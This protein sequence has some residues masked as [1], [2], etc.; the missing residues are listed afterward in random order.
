MRTQTILTS[1]VAFVGTL[2]SSGHAAAGY[3]V[4]PNGTTVTGTPTFLVY[5]DDEERLPYV[6]VSTSPSV[7]AYGWFTTPG[8]SC[9][10]LD[11][12]PEPRK[13]SCQV[14]YVTFTPGRT[15]YWIFTYWKNDDCVSYS[16]GT[17]CYPQKHVS[18]PFSFTV[19]A[20]PPPPAPVQSPPP[21]LPTPAPRPSGSGATVH[22]APKL[23]SLAAWSGE[24]SIKHTRLTSLVYSLMKGFGR[25]R[26]LAVACW[27]PDDWLSVLDAEGETA[28]QHGSVLRGFWKP[29][30]PRWLHLSPAVCDDLQALLDT[31]Q[32][33]G[34]RASAVSTLVHE[35]LHAHGIR[36]E[37][38]TNC[39]A[40]QL[41]P[42]LGDAL[43]MPRA[44][45]VRLGTLAVRHVR[46]HAP[47]RYWNA[48]KCR[49]GG[50]W[51]LEPDSPNL[52]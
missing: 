51:D 1:L 33:N 23:R 15:Y 47:A 45:A 7:D 40:V 43:Q 38:E 16:F 37:A 29:S 42:L 18:G 13:Y 14:S 50:R 52:H 4:Q 26:Q 19:A 28:T 32:P 27:A 46:S 8:V 31:G 24:R 34:R 30:Q 48:S 49:D 9:T 22:S 41:V 11:P 25:P 21:A 6:Q 12:Y 35:T 44:R 5:L 17:Y 2:L 20:P 39:Y 10:P 3:G 36:D